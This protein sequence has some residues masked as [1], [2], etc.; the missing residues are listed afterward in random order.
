M[1]KLN[2]NAVSLE[3]L[4][5]YA[6]VQEDDSIGYA[7]K[8]FCD[9]RAALV[10]EATP[11]NRAAAAKDLVDFLQFDF[12]WAHTHKLVDEEGDQVVSEAVRDELE[13][14]IEAYVSASEE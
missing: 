3:T 11:V 2:I 5:E 10:R 12:P 14:L 1:P 4:R 9:A 7:S 8:V 6:R 13:A